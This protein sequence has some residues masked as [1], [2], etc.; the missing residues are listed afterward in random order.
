MALPRPFTLPDKS[1]WPL[2]LLL[3][4]PSPPSAGITE[5]REEARVSSIEVKLGK[6][7]DGELTQ[8]LIMLVALQEDLRS[9]PSTHITQLTTA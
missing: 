5:W 4:C 9:I 6:Q 2:L 8:Q 3:Y 1:K 7:G